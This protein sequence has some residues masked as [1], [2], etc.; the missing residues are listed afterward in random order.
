MPTALRSSS[1][2]TRGWLNERQW[3]DVRKAAR[4]ARA[5][6]V[7]LKVHGVAVGS[8]RK[9]RT[10]CN[11]KG[12]VDKEQQQKSAES[13]V[14]MQL[15][16]SDASSPPP[17][18]KRRQRSRD[19]LLEFQRQK[20]TKLLAASTRVQLFLRQFRWQRMQNVWTAWKRATGGDITYGKRVQESTPTHITNNLPPGWTLLGSASGKKTKPKKP[21]AL[22]FDT[23][24]SG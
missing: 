17:L 3:L 10:V 20:R 15:A 8:L 1:A 21:R 18:S 23:S 4:I 5:E 6:R 7:V 12:G 24:P 16:D 11:Q 19:R 14:P 2:A 22:G 13:A 9:R